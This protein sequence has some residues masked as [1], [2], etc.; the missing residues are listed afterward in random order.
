MLRSPWM[1]SCLVSAKDWQLSCLY[2]FTDW[3]LSYCSGYW[4]LEEIGITHD[5]KWDNYG[6]LMKPLLIVR[7]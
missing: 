3:Q 4:N 6:E 7:N 2:S 1:D 5:Y